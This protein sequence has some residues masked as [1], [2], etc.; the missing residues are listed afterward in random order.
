MVDC[1]SIHPSTPLQRACESLQTTHA[2]ATAPEDDTKIQQIGVKVCVCVYLAG[3]LSGMESW[4]GSLLEGK[5]QASNE[6]RVLKMVS[7]LPALWLESIRQPS[8][9]QGESPPPCSHCLAAW[10]WDR[11]LHSDRIIPNLVLIYTV[12]IIHFYNMTRKTSSRRDGLIQG[13]HASTGLG[14]VLIIPDRL[15]HLKAKH[16]SEWDFIT[17]SPWDF[18]QTQRGELTQ[19]ADERQFAG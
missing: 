6:K 15:Y 8:S 10:K 14:V 5:H 11:W 3:W 12:H 4:E 13:F 1:A 9:W 19:T 16:V 17:A 2:W 7:W 18:L